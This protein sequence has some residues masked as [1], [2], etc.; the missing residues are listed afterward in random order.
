MDSQYASSPFRWHSN[1]PCHAFPDRIADRTSSMR[2]PGILHGWGVFPPR[3]S[4]TVQPAI[5]AYRRF[6]YSTFP[7]RS[8]MTMAE[9]L[10]S[11]ARRSFRT[12]RSSTLFR[13]VTSVKE[14]TV[15]MISF[16]EPRSGAALTDRKTFAPF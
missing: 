12:F 9:E 2:N 3:S 6:E 10:C 7:S 4:F 16:D 14:A 13:A 1:S 11:A 8:V 5:E 15:P